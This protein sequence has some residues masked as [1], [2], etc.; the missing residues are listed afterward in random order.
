MEAIPPCPKVEI[1]WIEVEEIMREEAYAK[2]VKD[3]RATYE[4]WDVRPEFLRFVPAEVWDM[5]EPKLL[6][7]LYMKFHIPPS[8]LR[9]M[10]EIAY[11]SIM[12]DALVGRM[13][14]LKLSPTFQECLE[15]PAT[16]H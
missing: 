13:I 6:R 7:H 11:L 1:E 2:E 4:T 10:D 5:M 16:K 14:E 3:E 15:K 8:K 12:R 9:N